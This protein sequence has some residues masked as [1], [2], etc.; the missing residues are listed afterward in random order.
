M[1][2][3]AGRV[4][5]PPFWQERGNQ[6]PLEWGVLEDTTMA[7]DMDAARAAIAAL[8]PNGMNVDVARHWLALWRDGAPPTLGRFDA[9]MPRSLMPAIMIFEIRRGATLM[10]LRAGEYTRLAFGFDMT[11]QSLLSFTNNVD[12]EDRLDWC[13]KVVEGAATISY[14]AIKPAQGA[15]IHAQGLTL[16]LSDRPPDGQ[17]YFFT[18]T[19]WRPNGGDWIEGS[20]ATDLQTPRERAMRSFALPPE[21][22]PSANR[23]ASGS[24][25]AR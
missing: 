1:A 19:N 17:R 13:W 15:V 21:A 20:V 11:G 18:H 7:W 8:R 9:Q 16:P 10:C 4:K 2:E 5:A 24:P 12:R 3:P 25:A 14:R 6:P 22:E 23:A